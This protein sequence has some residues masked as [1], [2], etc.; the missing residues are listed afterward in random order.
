MLDWSPEELCPEL[1]IE[2]PLPEDV[3]P[4]LLPIED[5]LPV[6]PELPAED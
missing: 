1:P 4:E 3:W 6:W 5:P 2:D